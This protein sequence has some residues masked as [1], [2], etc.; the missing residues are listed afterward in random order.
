MKN[1][2]MIMIIGIVIAMVITG[3][4]SNAFEKH[5]DL[6]NESTLDY[7]KIYSFKTNYIGDASK[8]AGLVRS[9]HYSQYIQDGI[10]LRTR[11]QPYGIEVKYVVSNLKNYEHVQAEMLE[12]AVI[13]FSL[14]DNAD[15]VIMRFSDGKDYYEY[16][17]ARPYIRE[18]IGI[19]LAFFGRDYDTFSNGL[20]P[21]L[22]VQEWQEG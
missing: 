11:E 4:Q 3:C 18:L 15:Q 13:I 10:A 5:S 6:Q 20:V 21:V 17:F 22:E 1:W 8:T 16:N 14:I 9:L 19:E 7:Q 2:K 12:N